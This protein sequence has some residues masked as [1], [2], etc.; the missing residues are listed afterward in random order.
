MGALW[1]AFPE[2]IFEGALNVQWTFEE[3]PIEA[4]RRAAEKNA[5][6]REPGGSVSSN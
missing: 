1:K 3:Q 2:W 4:E 6:R 5:F